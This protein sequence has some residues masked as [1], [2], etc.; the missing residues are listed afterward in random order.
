MGNTTNFNKSVAGPNVLYG[1]NKSHV[2][3]QKQVKKDIIVIKIKKK[4]SK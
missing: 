2:F 1:K 3:S 4:I